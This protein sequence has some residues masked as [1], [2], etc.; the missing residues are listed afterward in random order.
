MNILLFFLLISNTYA[1]IF[2]NPEYRLLQNLTS[3]YQKIIPNFEN[4]VDVQVSLALRAINKMNQVEGTVD[5][6]IWLRHYWHDEYL[7]WNPEE[8]NNLSMITLYTDPELDNSIWIPDLY[9][10]NTGEKPMDNMDY[11]KANIYSNGDVFWSRPGI[12]TSTCIFDLTDFPFDQQNCELKFSS[13]AYHGDIINL[14]THQNAI[15]ITNFQSNDGWSLISYTSQLNL[16]KYECCKEP[17]P[18]ITFNFILRRKP[19]YYNLNIILPT[20]ATAT[21]MILTLFVPWN[22]GE[23]IS[24]AVTVFLSI[25][26]FL[27]ILS[28]NLPKTNSQPL[29]SRMLIGLTFFSLFVVFLTIIISALYS[30]KNKK[31]P[32]W[33]KKYC[34]NKCINITEEDK[35]NNPEEHSSN[36]SPTRYDSYVNAL[37]NYANSHNENNELNSESYKL[38]IYKSIKEIVQ[39][40]SDDLDDEND[41]NDEE[42]CS[43]FKLARTLELSFTFIF[44]LTF[45]IFCIVMFSLIPKY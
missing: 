29:L 14:T 15:D 17:Y 24:F 20:F 28:E 2:N 36:E 35:E 31:L 3:N 6:N 39:K 44:M 23:R 22:S 37:S 5:L 11:T 43:Y 8:Y 34:N 45:L 1:N 32:E 12:I 10:I 26:V 16:V 38:D 7:I 30:K 21:L 40:I 9:L 4:K 41:P 27:L 13:W 25:I 19:G 33:L 42:E 18:D